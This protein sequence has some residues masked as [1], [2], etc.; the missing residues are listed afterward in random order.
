MKEIWKSI[1]N[2]PRYEVSN[3]G[4]VRSYHGHD[5]KSPNAGKP[6][7]KPKIKKLTFDKGCGYLRVGLFNSEG[8]ILALVHQLVL[9]A[10]IGPRPEGMESCHNDGDRLNNHVDNLRWDTRINNFKDRDKHGNTI[11]G[12]N[13]L[14][15]ITLY[16]YRGVGTVYGRV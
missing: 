15:R 10:F 11:R 8:H 6:L 16:R 14:R 3:L 13:A 9:T 2:Y 1:P 12:E 7:S 5:F 4:R